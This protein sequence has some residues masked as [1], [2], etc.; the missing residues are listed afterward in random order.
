MNGDVLRKIMLHMDRRTIQTLF[1]LANN[2]DCILPML[3]RYSTRLNTLSVER[4]VELLSKA[5][6]IRKHDL[7]LEYLCR[8]STDKAVRVL[9]R[10]SERAN[11]SDMM[12]IADSLGSPHGSRYN[13]VIRHIEA[14]RSRRSS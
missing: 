10:L 5:I 7:V 8:L 2:A 9:F 6:E 4:L 1:P 14:T 13:L 12:L 3:H 11:P